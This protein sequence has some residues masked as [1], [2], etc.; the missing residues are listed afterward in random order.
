MTALLVSLLAGVGGYSISSLLAPR[1]YGRPIWLD[2]GVGEP[3]SLPV[4]L[5]TIGQRLE[6]TQAGRLV[7]RALRPVEA[8]TLV[9][10]EILLGLV[11]VI[12]LA[13]GVSAAG[14]LWSGPALAFALLYAARDAQR[15]QLR[16]LNASWETDVVALLQQVRLAVVAGL[17][18]RQAVELAAPNAQ[19]VA[20]QIVTNLLGQWSA[21]IDT[22]SS[23]QVLGRETAP[24]ASTGSFFQL[25]ATTVRMGTSLRPVLDA[26]VERLRDKRR[27]RLTLALERLPMKLAGFRGLG[28]LAALALMF[29]WAFSLVANVPGTFGS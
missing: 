25:M 13:A 8:A 4:L 14:P 6:A 12:S 27:A 10:R 11:G 22:A 16:E 9:Q 28:M 19:G 1:S 5:R 15:E 24:D 29:A 26:E 2:A 3:G 7:G 17:T 21:G 23:L 18:L 20:Q